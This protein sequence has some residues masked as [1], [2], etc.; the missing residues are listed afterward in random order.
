MTPAQQ[1]AFDQCWPRY[2]IEYDGERLDMDSLFKR[3]GPCILEI[4]FGMGHSLVAMAEASP[5]INFIGVEV[6]RPGV[7]KLFHG[8]QERGV[9]NIRVYCHDAVDILR[10]CISDGVLDGIQ[11]FFPDPWHK[12]KHHKRRL[13]Q[14]ELVAQLAQKLK[15]KGTIH[16]ATDWEHYA[17]QMMAVMSAERTLFNSYGSGEFAPQGGGRPVTKFERRGE[18]LGHDVWDLVFERR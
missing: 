15:Q 12:K 10:D 7:G 6:H 9:D 16:L 14:P 3:T 1:R 4:G 11:I 17:H 2:G 8:M 5:G 18:R 13:V